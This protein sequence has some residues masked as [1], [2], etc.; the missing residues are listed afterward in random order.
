MVKNHSLKNKYP[1]INLISKK[2]TSEILFSI[3]QVPKNYT[4]I[5]QSIEIPINHTLFSNRLK[6]LQ[7]LDLI[8]KKKYV[9]NTFY[10]ISKKGILIKE[11]ITELMKISI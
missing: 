6:E 10:S 11:K 2:W 7:K 5:Y 4:E 1:I 8:N 9:E 3:T